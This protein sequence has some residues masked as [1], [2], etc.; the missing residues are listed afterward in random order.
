ML[1][2]RVEEA[3]R[4]KMQEDDSNLDDASIRVLTQDCH[5]H[6][7]NVWIGAVVKRLSTYLNELLACDLNAIDFRLRVSTMFDAVLRALDKEFSLPGNY[8]KGHGPWFKHWL[9]AFHSGA[10]LV[11]VERTAGSRQDMAC[12]GAAAVYWNRK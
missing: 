2:A 12:Q 1:S 8:P 4:Q 11:P 7:R 9:K 3:V 6:L 10:L 5:H